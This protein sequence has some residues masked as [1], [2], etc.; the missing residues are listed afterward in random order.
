LFKPRKYKS[1][2]VTWREDSDIP[3]ATQEIEYTDFPLNGI[4]LWVE[5]DGEH[6]VILLPSE[7]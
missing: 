5:N 7:N 2:I 4:D 6:R 1:G 3:P